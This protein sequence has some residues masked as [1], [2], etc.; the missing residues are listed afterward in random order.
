M[1]LCKHSFIRYTDKV[2]K[3]LSFFFHFNKQFKL[4]C[5]YECNTNNISVSYIKGRG[6][7]ALNSFIIGLSAAHIRLNPLF[8]L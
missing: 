6:S 8:R 5:V 7:S 3:V 2:E 1:T 4:L